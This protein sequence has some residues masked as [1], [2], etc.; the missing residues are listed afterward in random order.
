MTG[1]LEWQYINYLQVGARQ[2]LRQA[3]FAYWD[4]YFELPK[5]A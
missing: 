2:R 5:T 3:G 1:N 4:N